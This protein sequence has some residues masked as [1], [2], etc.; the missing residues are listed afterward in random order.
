[1][2][3]IL[4]VTDNARGA[5]DWQKELVQAGYPVASCA[6]E[7]ES[8]VQ[9]LVPRPPDI[10]ILDGGHARLTPKQLRD[11]VS[12]HFSTCEALLIWLATEDQTVRL[13]P[14]IGLDDFAVLPCSASEVLAR[15]RLLLWRTHRVDAGDL[16][17]AGD[18]VI[19]QANYSVSIHGQPLELTYKEYE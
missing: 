7:S 2:Q 16:M 4:I 8:L 15:V 19:D 14:S 18:L 17:V 3:R 6:A 13:D 11:T 1:M 9:A 10:F 5:A 12:Q